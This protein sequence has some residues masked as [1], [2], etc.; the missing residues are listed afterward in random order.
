MESLY[1][2]PLRVYLLLA[3]AALWGV[4]SGFSLPVSLFPT[5]SQPKFSVRVSYGSLTPQQFFESIG[6]QLEGKLR[7]IRMDQSGVKDLVA[8]YS[9]NGAQYDIDFNWGANAAEAKKHIDTEIAALLSSQ[10]ENIR[11]S[12]SV[13]QMKENSGFL[14]VSFYSPLRS[15]DEVYDTLEPLIDPM[16]ARVLDAD[17]LV[18]YNPTQKEIT[19]RLR[20][21]LLAQHQLS[22]AQVERALREAV[23]ALNGGTLKMGERSYQ[24]NFPKKAMQI[25]EL[26]FIRITP[27]NQ[28]PV[29]LKDIANISV[30]PAI[31]NQRKF[32]TS[33]V[34]SVILFATPKEG[35]N[36]KRMSDDI[37][38]E[39]EKLM[40]K[41]P[42][43]I[44]YKVLI[45][46]SEFINASIRSV[47]KEVGLAAFL[48]VV[49]LFLFIGNV[50]NVATA[51]IEIPL[52]LIMAF[53][54]M[55][56]TGMNL[57]LISLGGLALSAGM[58]VDASVVVLESI[59]RH[60]EKH[61]ETLSRS[62][63]LKIL[64]E[65]V[66]E[67][68]LPI[69]AATIASLVVFAPLIL[70]QGLTNSLLGDLAK[71]VIFSHGLSA[72]VALILVPT[73]RLQLMGDGQITHSVSP[74]EGVIV[75]VESGYRRVL[76]RFLENGRAQLITLTAIV[77][78]LPLLFMLIVPRLKKEVV[79][80]PESDFVMVG[81]Y[82][83]ASTSIKNMEAE[84]DQ[85]ETQIR[86]TFKDDIK[87][88]FTQIN[89]QKNAH[90]M[91]KVTSRKRAAALTE[92][93]EE[94]FKNTPTQFFWVEQYNP[95]ELEIPDP[96]EFELEIIGGK[97]E[98]R[99][100]MAQDLMAR[101]YDEGIFDNGR[102]VRPNVK[103]EL[104]LVAL[105]IRQFQ[106]SHEVLSRFDFSH[107]L[108]TALNGVFVD[109][110]YALQRSFPLYLRFPEE[111]ADRIEKIKALPFGFEGRIIPLGALA[112]FTLKERPP[113]EYRRNLT[114]MVR[115]TA[116]T[117]KIE[118]HRVGEYKEKARALVDEFQAKGQV[119]ASAGDRPTFNIAV[120]DRELLDALDQLKWAIVISIGLI[121]LTMVI[122]L[123]D[124]MQALLVLVAIPLGFIGVLLSL[125]AFGSTLSLN[126]A[127]GTILL[128]GI[129]VANSI[130]L[131]DFIQK[132]FSWGQSALNATVIASTTRLRPIAMTSMTTGL[133]M[134]PI[135]IGLGEGGKILQPL[136]IAVCGGLGVS[137]LM[138]LF[139]VPALQYHWLRF[140][141]R[142]RRVE[143]T[144]AQPL[145]PHG[146]TT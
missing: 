66:N 133:G 72:V 30:G 73:I 76:T 67:V 125:Y 13:R 84:I 115:I 58:N 114:P 95:S 53:I 88:T 101:M 48:A 81:I 28:V 43:D 14:A 24:V 2:K 12:V 60:F 98:L 32:K 7:A 21:A 138:T 5:S 137:T 63:K 25:E 80:K 142:T 94:I 102:Q 128:N 56:M 145:Q 36:I 100:Q 126:S 135:A 110:F 78:L 42:K 68:K 70:T 74:A 85:V 1:S 144:K 99:Q 96:P 4:L 75:A 79:G 33:G 112:E 105:P 143:A 17:E 15:L 129:A 8:E 23:I 124:I 50:R 45:N 116:K 134:L 136:G 140:K 39:V 31:D 97:K 77:V 69:I 47:I 46:P 37:M 44:E 26:G 54:L 130:I 91:A 62:E 93:F 104:E 87:Y 57:N 16:Q 121:F 89:G 132:Q 131:V 122:Q 19:I 109:N 18:L 86:E 61:K 41:V 111:S 108:R 9:S 11:R 146:A 10:E 120:P 119:I 55:K 106:A 49:V 127:L 34:E 6:N 35:G 64:I 29:L 123:G 59:F 90:V 103:P 92:K 20:P 52:S 71:A 40:P 141:E 82:S 83:V 27:V 3:A 38:A 51:A 22:T 118:Q 65:A 117:K 113:E 139:I 107:F